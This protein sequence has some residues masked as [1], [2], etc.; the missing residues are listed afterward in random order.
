M[1]WSPDGQYLVTGRNDDGTKVWKT[2]SFFDAAGFATNDTPYT[3]L[4]D[5][6]HTTNYETDGADFSPNNQ[7]LATAAD[8]YLMVYS[9]PNFTEIQD[10]SAGDGAYLLSSGLISGRLH[11]WDTSIWPT[12]GSIV[13][14][15][16]DAVAIVQAQE[17]KRQIEFI[18]VFDDKVIVSGDEGN[19]Y[20]YQFD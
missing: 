5:R 9:L 18:D 17:A 10:I 19:I 14:A 8:E 7:W 16:D 11:I 20:L 4:E 13:L 15:S 1:V 3:H 2:N 12:S 6:G